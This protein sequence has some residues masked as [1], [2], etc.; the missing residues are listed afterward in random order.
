MEYNK[1]TK[2]AI[3]GAGAVGAYFG[4]CM[5]EAGY[6]VEFI[7]R[8]EHL[9]AMQTNG[10]IV[11]DVSN[12]VVIHK[13]V[14]ANN[15]LNGEYDIIFIAV[16]SGQTDDVAKLCANHLSKSG[17][18]VSLQNGIENGKIIAKYIPEECVI[19]SAV[20]ITANIKCAGHM[21][22]ITAGRMAYNSY[23]ESGNERALALK[24]LLDNTKI[25]HKLVDD[26]KYTQ[27]QKLM[28]NVI[29]NPLTALFGFVNRDFLANNEALSLAK[30]LFDEARLAAA[31]EGVDLPEELFEKTIEDS[32]AY[33]GF[34]SS[35]LQ[36]IEANRCP[37]V[38]GILGAVARVHR[39]NNSVA[40]HTEMLIKIMD[41]KYGGWF[42]TSS[43]VAA[44]VL[45]AA[46]RKVLLIERKNEPHGYAIP[47]GFVNK[48][49]RVEDAAVRELCEETG[50]KADV[51]DIELLGV[52]SDR[53]RDPRGHTIGVVY[54]YRADYE[55]EAVAMDDAKGVEYFDVDNLPDEIA[56]DH[57]EIIKDFVSKY[58]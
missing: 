53:D 8:G 36:D 58:L 43:I 15:L 4:M 6:D 47:G 13:Q 41:V 24:A 12:N 39:A 20:Y 30:Q 27:W 22:F 50:I 57:R 44:D 25:S 49:E 3:Y 40:V 7:A 46:G 48:F 45:V 17:A 14:K 38:D 11:E 55:L 16:K 5:L 21:Q 56:F 33:S 9:K 42:H 18:I 28:L 35:M 1:N 54:L 26:I 2:I 19:P 32:K 51:A 34:K 29:F 52:Y 10:L 23:A 37:E 31:F